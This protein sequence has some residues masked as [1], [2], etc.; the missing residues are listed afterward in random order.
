MAALAQEDPLF[1]GL[2]VNR[3]GQDDR[4]SPAPQTRAHP[5]K[6]AFVAV[7]EGWHG[8]PAASSANRVSL[9]FRGGVLRVAQGCTVA[10]AAL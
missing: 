9:G 5:V 3:A 6:G 10:E 2:R 7:R 8:D 1:Q 4:Q